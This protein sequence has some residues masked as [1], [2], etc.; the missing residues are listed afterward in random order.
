MTR[1]SDRDLG[2]GRDIARRDFLQGMAVGVTLGT[3]KG[4]G[5]GA[6]SSFGRLRM[7]RPTAIAT[8]TSVASAAAHRAR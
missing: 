7:A 4:E 2:M 5:S 6:I 8:R 1:K 3:T